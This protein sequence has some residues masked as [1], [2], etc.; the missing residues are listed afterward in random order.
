MLDE[1]ARASMAATTAPPWIGRIISSGIFLRL[2][3]FKDPKNRTGMFCILPVTNVIIIAKRFNPATPRQ[4]NTG[5]YHA[6]LKRE[7]VNDF[8][9]DNSSFLRVAMHEG[10]GR[11]LERRLFGDDLPS[12]GVRWGRGLNAGN[13]KALEDVGC[14]TYDFSCEPLSWGGFVEW[15]T[16]RERERER[17]RERTEIVW[18]M[19]A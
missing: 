13:A 3:D 9:G 8:G 10:L 6:R 4:N 7:D 5:V 15:A 1:M 12:V 18:L 11:R 14:E 16:K 2:L 17:D 19:T